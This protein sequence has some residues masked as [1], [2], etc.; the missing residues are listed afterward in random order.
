MVEVLF[1]M[2]K[3]GNFL[4]NQL[5]TLKVGLYF[6][7]DAIHFSSRGISRGAISA[8]YAKTSPT[9]AGPKLPCNL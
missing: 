5:I 2:M 3:P 8:L 6:L 9:P 4:R 7:G 1:C